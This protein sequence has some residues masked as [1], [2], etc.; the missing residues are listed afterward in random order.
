MKLES[1]MAELENVR[2][3]AETSEFQ[4][5]SERYVPALIVDILVKYIGNKKV[6]EAV[7]EIPF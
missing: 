2:N 1:L 6:E 7:N 4:E 3:R 5:L